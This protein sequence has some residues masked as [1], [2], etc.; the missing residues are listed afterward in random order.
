LYGGAETVDELCRRGGRRFG[1]GVE[2]FYQFYSTRLNG[3]EGAYTLMK[4]SW[5]GW[6]RRDKGVGLKRL[7]IYSQREDD[8]KLKGM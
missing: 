7:Y 5:N 3:G 2:S 6:M 8:G 4:T 1:G